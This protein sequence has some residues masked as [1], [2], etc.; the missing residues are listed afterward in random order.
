[1]ASRARIAIGCPSGSEA[2]HLKLNSAA[3]AGR[4]RIVGA[5]TAIVVP[6]SSVLRDNFIDISSLELESAARG[7]LSPRKVPVQRNPCQATLAIFAATSPLVP[8][9]DDTD[10]VRMSPLSCSGDLYCVLPFAK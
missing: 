4:R 10:M 9:N 8:G 6:A 5:A 3:C 7:C 2:P 1:M